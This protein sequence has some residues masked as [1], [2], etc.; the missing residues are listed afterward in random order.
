MLFDLLIDLGGDGIQTLDEL[1]LLFKG[2]G[3][4]IADARRAGSYL[5]PY[6]YIEY[7]DDVDEPSDPIAA[8]Q[9]F[10]SQL[11]SQHVKVVVGGD[12]G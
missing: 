8:C 9:F 10:A 4:R 1:I 5:A 11:A 7:L 2:S 12:G 6:L 3:N